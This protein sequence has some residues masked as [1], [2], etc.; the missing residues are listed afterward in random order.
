MTFVAR[1]LTTIIV[2]TLLGAAM[3]ACAADPEDQP[4][5]SV[6]VPVVPNESIVTARIIAVNNV[7]GALPW[8]LVIEIVSVEDVPGY[9]NLLA[10]RK[11]ETIAVL[12]EENMEGFS[13]EAVIKAR[14]CYEGD[15][16]TRYYSG[17][18]IAPAG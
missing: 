16:R 4:P 11:G 6:K 2:C 1:T 7:G 8:E 5:P 3:P 10:N 15:E 18:E 9:Q 12:S 17:R 13:R 14:I